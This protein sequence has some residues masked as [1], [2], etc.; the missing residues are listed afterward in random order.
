M[1][2]LTTNDDLPEQGLS[3]HR[4]RSAQIGNELPRS[5]LHWQRPLHFPDAQRASAPSVLGAMQSLMG[6]AQLP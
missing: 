6:G 1:P 2:R 4:T 3:V 5:L